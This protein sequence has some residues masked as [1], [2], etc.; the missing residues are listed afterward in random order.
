ML[1][2]YVGPKLTDC[3]KHLSNRCSPVPLVVQFA[4]NNSKCQATGSTPFFLA[5][6]QHP[7]TLGTCGLRA[8]DHGTPYSRV[9]R[10]DVPTA[11]EVVTSWQGAV[12]CAKACLQGVITWPTTTTPTVHNQPTHTDSKSSSALL[13][14]VES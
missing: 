8:G 6:G 1:H 5:Y 9:K 4:T 11:K 10:T 12:D 13:D 2:H 3:N 7:A 14:E